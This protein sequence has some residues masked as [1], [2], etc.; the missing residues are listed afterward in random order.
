MPH[1][2]VRQP[3]PEHQLWFDAPGQRLRGGTLLV[4]QTNGWEKVWHSSL[5]N[6]RHLPNVVLKIQNIRSCILLGCHAERSEKSLL[7]RS[8]MPIK[9]FECVF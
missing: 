8:P 9:L 7:M 4:E 6:P 2:S 1:A 3:H 5:N